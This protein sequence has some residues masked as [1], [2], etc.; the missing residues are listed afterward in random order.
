MG[1]EAGG[2]GRS[3]FGLSWAGD[4][5]FLPILLVTSQHPRIAIAFFIFRFG[6]SGTEMF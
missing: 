4:Y 2:L 5:C 6:S 1:S 3:L